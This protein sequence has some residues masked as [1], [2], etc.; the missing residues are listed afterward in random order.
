MT[1]T[2]YDQVRAIVDDPDTFAERLHVR[3]TA[4][5]IS[6]NRLARQMNICPTQLSRWMT[7]RVRPNTLSMLKMD[8]AA[9]QLI[10][11]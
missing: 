5:G 7:G 2:A 3:L 9:D 4:H 1:L 8:A 6:H 10:Y 11:G